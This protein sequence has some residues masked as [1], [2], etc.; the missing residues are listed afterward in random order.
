MQWPDN[1]GT[2]FDLSNQYRENK[3]YVT[4]GGEQ[5]QIVGEAAR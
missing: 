1:V 3:R 4:I 5:F 2:G